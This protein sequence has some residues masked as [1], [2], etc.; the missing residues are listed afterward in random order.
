MTWPAVLHDGGRHAVALQ[1]A[2]DVA[3]RVYAARRDPAVAGT[4]ADPGAVAGRDP[5]GELVALTEL[6]RWLSGVQDELL[7]A[8]RVAHERDGGGPGSW[9]DLASALGVTRTPARRRFE[10]V[11]EG[12][13]RGGGLPANLLAWDVVRRE[14]PSASASEERRRRPGRTDD[15]GR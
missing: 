4:G 5:L 11:A 8:V 3:A 6:M 9:E 1:V 7:H 2:F 10:L 14:P 13:R 15:R 12:K